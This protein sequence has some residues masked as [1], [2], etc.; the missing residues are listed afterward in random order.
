MIIGV[1][2]RPPALMSSGSLAC[3][4]IDPSTVAIGPEVVGI[5]GGY[6]RWRGNHAG[7]GKIDRVEVYGIR[8]LL[9]QI[10]DKNEKTFKGSRLK[11][12]I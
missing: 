7:V 5:E 9:R 6:L 8:L 12:K 1:S 3:H 10:S 4:R 11:V 2:H